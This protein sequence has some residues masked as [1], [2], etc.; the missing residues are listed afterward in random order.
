METTIIIWNSGEKDREVSHLEIYKFRF[1]ESISNNLWIAWQVLPYGP[2]QGTQPM[3][4]IVLS[5]SGA[6]LG[7]KMETG[8]D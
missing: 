4:V 8:T 7:P 6:V 2:Y 3:D 1:R 5:G